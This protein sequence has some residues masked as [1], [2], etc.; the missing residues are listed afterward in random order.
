MLTTTNKE[1]I[2]A[3]PIPIDAIQIQANPKSPFY[4]KMVYLV[5]NYSKIIYI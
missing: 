1:E 4:P 3:N 5:F 2:I